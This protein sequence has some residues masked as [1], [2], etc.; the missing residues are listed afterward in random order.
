MYRAGLETILGL[1]RRGA[2]FVVDPCIPSSWPEYRIDWKFLDTR[3]VITVANPSR[4]CRGVAE[5]TLDGRPVDS[6][7][8][9]LVNDGAEH[10]VTVV[11]GK[12]APQAPAG[13]SRPVTAT[14]GMK[15]TP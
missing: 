1:R 3:Y 11:L 10:H 15:E 2:T 9:P 4:R 14:V 6:T 5:V 12:R 7:V 13:A 8:I